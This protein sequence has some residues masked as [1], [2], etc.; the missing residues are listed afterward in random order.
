MDFI[1]LMHFINYPPELSL[2][3]IHSETLIEHWTIFLTTVTIIIT[4]RILIITVNIK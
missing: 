2:F 4:Y 1:T 3:E